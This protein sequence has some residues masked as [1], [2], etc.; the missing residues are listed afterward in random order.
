LCHFPRWLGFSPCHLSSSPGVISHCPEDWLRTE[1]SWSGTKITNTCH[2]LPTP[3]TPKTHCRWN[4]EYAPDNTFIRRDGRRACA[5][6]ASLTGRGAVERCV[7]IDLGA[8]VHAEVSARAVA[9]LTSDGSPQI[10]RRVWVTRAAGDRPLGDDDPKLK[11]RPVLA[12]CGRGRLIVAGLASV[13]S[14]RPATR[15]HAPRQRS[16]TR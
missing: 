1:G 5:A 13:S 8:G 4:H 6:S 14:A 7:A 11:R 9:A 2:P 15:N 16:D 3:K 10:M 12:A